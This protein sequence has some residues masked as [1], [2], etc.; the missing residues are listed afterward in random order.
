MPL[1]HKD[2]IHSPAWR[3]MLEGV[4][5]AAD[6]VEIRESA[7]RATGYLRCLTDFGLVNLGQ[8]KAMAERIDTVS[9][10]RLAALQHAAKGSAD[11][12]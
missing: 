12:W 11:P 2:D 6:Y 4:D 3:N 7:A 8:H 5:R 9:N 10:R 1:P